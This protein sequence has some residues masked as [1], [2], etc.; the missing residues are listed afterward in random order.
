MFA[1]C[2][3]NIVVARICYQTSQRR[4]KNASEVRRVAP[5]STMRMSGA[6]NPAAK[7]L[8]KDEA[9]R[10]AAN[11]AKLPETFTQIKS[12]DNRRGQGEQH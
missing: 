9:R 1:C 8:T 2:E 10:I 4:M 12:P 7:P 11:I 5:A 6:G 3:M